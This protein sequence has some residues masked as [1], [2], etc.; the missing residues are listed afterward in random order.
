MPIQFTSAM[1]ITK[2]SSVIQISWHFYPPFTLIPV[3]RNLFQVIGRLQD[4]T[5]IT[6]S[7][8]I[9]SMINLL[10]EGFVSFVKQM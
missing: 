8:I 4:R 2:Y 5:V 3:G 6:E 7:P 1:S 9:H 10:S